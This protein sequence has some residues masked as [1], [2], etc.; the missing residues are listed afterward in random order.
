MGSSRSSG[1]AAAQ[2]LPVAITLVSTSVIA[3]ILL[4]LKNLLLADRD[5]LAPPALVPGQRDVLA[6]HLGRRALAVPH[7]EEHVLAG[8]EVGRVG[9]PGGPF[10]ASRTSSHRHEYTADQ[11]QPQT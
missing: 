2:A 9:F 11:Q 4:T 3:T 10:L 5:R 1:G 7:R 8:R 6:R